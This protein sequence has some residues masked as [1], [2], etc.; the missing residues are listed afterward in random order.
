MIVPTRREPDWQAVYTRRWEVAC[1]QRRLMANIVPDV[2]MTTNQSESFNAQMKKLKTGRRHQQ[3]RWCWYCT[4]CSRARVFCGLRN[5]E[6]CQGVICGKSSAERSAN[7]QLS[8]FRIL[9]P[10][11]SAFPRI[12]K[13][14]FARI[15]QQMYNRCLAASG[16]PGSFPAVFFVV[17]LPK[18]RVVVLQ[19]RLILKSLPHSK[20]HVISLVNV[21]G[22]NLYNRYNS[23]IDNRTKP[24]MFNSCDTVVA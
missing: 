16:V 20:C 23:R 2:H 13:L 9:Q 1:V 21:I 11:N 7:Y 6:S 17:R 24:I 18:N 3:T 8:L 12:T 19:F 5:A 15:V 22:F 14:P 10:K 4:A